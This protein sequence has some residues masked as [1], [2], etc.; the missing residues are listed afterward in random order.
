MFLASTNDKVQ[1]PNGH[2][3]RTPSYAATTHKAQGMTVDRVQVLAT[4]GM[5]RHGAYVAMSRHRAKDMASNYADRGKELVSTPSA[6]QPKR[7]IFAGL[8]LRRPAG[9]TEQTKAVPELPRGGRFD[10]LRIKAQA[11]ERASAPSPVDPSCSRIAVRSW[12]WTL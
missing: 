2:A 6:Q 8:Q 9:L 10:G 3:A 4:P 11:I 1:A 5:D 12:V 7:D